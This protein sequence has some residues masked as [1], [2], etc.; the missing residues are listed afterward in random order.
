MNQEKPGIDRDRAEETIQ[1]LNLYETQEK[2]YTRRL[3]GFHRN[4]KKWTW[5]PLLGAYFILPWINIDGRQSVWFDLPARQFHV[6][7]FTFWPQDF[8][9]LGWL[10]IIAAFAL[11]TV[12]V[13]VGRVW[14]GYSCPQTVWTMLFMNAEH[15]WEGDRNQRIKLDKAPWSTNKVAR[16]TGKQATWI[17]IAFVTGI[18]FVGYFNPIRELVPDFFTLGAH[19]AAYFWTFF[20]T[21]ATYLNAGFMREQVCLYMCPYARFQSV[22]F[23]RDTLI[24]SYDAA[25][26]E[27]RGARKKGAAHREEGLGDCTDCTLCVQVCPTGIDIRD[28]LQYECISCGLCIDACDA[29]M[30]KMGYPRKLISFTT[31]NALEGGK[32]H[33]LR[34]RFVGYTLVLAVM[35]GL[36]IYALAARVPLE[37]DIIRDRTLLYRETYQG[38]VENIYTLKI[39][40]MEERE[41]SY[42]ISVRGEHDYEFIGD[43]EVNVPGGSTYTGVV[44]LELDPGLMRDPNSELEFVVQSLDD[45]QLRAAE[46]TRFIG[47]SIHRRTQ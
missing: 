10:L 15:F 8:M 41:H 11:F 20:F 31:E 4:L 34:P 1:V 47:P 38:M 33:I 29:V 35:V 9:L 45:A 42:A 26:G 28:G 22:M 30:D 17:L 44:R 37:V 2:I 36:F 24:V 14:C 16:K 43:R 40:N 6:F 12:T 21:G 23:D 18:T 32:T 13:L 27:P 46:D 39:N 25:R 5:I 19:P 7:G 3:E